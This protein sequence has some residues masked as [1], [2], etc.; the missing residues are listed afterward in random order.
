MAAHATNPPGKT[1]IASGP[2]N[3]RLVASPLFIVGSPRSGTSILVDAMFAAG[4]HGFREGNLL[5]L[6]K[7]L[8]DRV[9]DHFRRFRLP[10]PA[11]DKTLVGNVDLNA[12]KC[13]IREV[14]KRVIEDKNQLSP[15]LDKTGNVETILVIPD[16][17]EMSPNCRVIF[18]KRRAI[19]NVLSRL[20]KFPALGFADHCRQWT[21]T[22]SAW[23]QI[24]DGIEAWR[25]LEVDQRDLVVRPQVVGHDIAALVGLDETACT[26]I[27]QT[28]RTL[29]PQQ[30]GPGTAERVMPLDDTG[31]TP[32][33]IAEF[34]EICGP[35]LEAW[36]YSLDGGYR[37]QP[38]VAGEPDGFQN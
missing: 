18:A 33:Q 30:T 32:A 11:G 34:V 36:G 38:P 10:S 2:G 31:W 28:F 13:G 14:F 27:E 12:I 29:R 17:V 37:K 20:Q 26:R 24:R 21:L 4:F 23:R 25:Y 7:P 35:E 1:A 6:L 22:M 3:Q 19:E 9:D 5:G 16:L 8:Y 15:W